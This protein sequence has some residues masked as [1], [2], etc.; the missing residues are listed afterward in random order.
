MRCA[1]RNSRIIA[2]PT[3]T[4]PGQYRR[5]GIFWPPGL[6]KHDVYDLTRNAAEDVEYVQVNEDEHDNKRVI[7][8]LV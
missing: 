4:L 1:F 6:S 3:G 7:I 2:W 8:E 5:E